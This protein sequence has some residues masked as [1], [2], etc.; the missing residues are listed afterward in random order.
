[1]LDFV[2]LS[3]P[4]C[5]HKLQITEEINRFACAASGNEHIVNRSGGIITLK[6]VFDGITKV[7]MGVDR[8]IYSIEEIMT[9]Y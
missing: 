3:C 2:T 8:V 7:K 9:I 5:G 6:L 1:M 4:S